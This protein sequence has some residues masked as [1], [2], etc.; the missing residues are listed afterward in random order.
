MQRKCQQLGIEEVSELERGMDFR[1][2]EYRRE[3]FL[4]FYEFHLKYRAHAGAVYQFLPWLAKH[5]NWDLEQRLWFATINGMTQHALT[6]LAIFE[7]LPTANFT[8]SQYDYFKDWFNFIWDILPF[9]TDRRYQKRDCIRAVHA[10]GEAVKKYGSLKN[11]YTG[12]FETV[13]KRVRTEL[14]SLGRLG[15]WSGLE[16]IKIAA[17]GELEIEFNTL[18]L[19]DRSGSKSH[20]NGLCKVLGRDDLDWWSK[21]N[22]SFDGKYTD[23]QFD[24]LENEGAA[25]LTE[26]ISRFIDRDFIGDVGYETLETALCTYKGWHRPNRRYPNIYNDMAYSRILDT[27]RKNPSLKTGLFWQ[28]RADYLP[29]ELRIE[30]AANEHPQYGKLPLNRGIQNMYRLTGKIPFMGLDWDCFKL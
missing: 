25:L 15:A 24:W 28:A 8:D 26:S 6:S 2:P 1:K 5:F 23:E 17:E 4:R 13:W 19:R 7:Q 21:G 14:H 11:F 12:D 22:P 29:D 30:V 18:M 10:V 3:V 9:D 27:S 16:F 20:R